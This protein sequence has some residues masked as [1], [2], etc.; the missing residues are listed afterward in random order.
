MRRGIGGD[1]EKTLLSDSAQNRTST[2]SKSA[3]ERGREI[4]IPDQ[5]PAEENHSLELSSD[6]KKPLC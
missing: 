3:R 6:E 4:K 1:R 5:P 2:R